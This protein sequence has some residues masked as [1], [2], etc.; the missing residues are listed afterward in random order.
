MEITV[1]IIYFMVHCHKLQNKCTIVI[2]MHW[3]IMAC[4]GELNVFQDIVSGLW[5]LVNNAGIS[6]VASGPIEWLRTSDFREVL[7]VN[8]LGVVDVTLKFLPLLKK[9][10]GRIRFWY[11]DLSALCLTFIVF[12]DVCRYKC[13]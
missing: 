11:L 3:H 7:D 6:G 8:T 9:G 1:K 12:V 13:M 10:K 4:S 2:V 5:G